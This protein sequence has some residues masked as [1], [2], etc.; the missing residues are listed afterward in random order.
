MAVTV[1][2]GRDRGQEVRD[3]GNSM[4]SIYKTYKGAKDRDERKKI[5]DD[6]LNDEAKKELDLDDGDV[7]ITERKGKTAGAG[8]LKFPLVDMTDYS[9]PS[10]YKPNM[11]LNN[12][13]SF[14]A[15]GTKV[16]PSARNIPTVLYRTP[17]INPYQPLQY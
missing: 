7:D 9:P 15:L 12:Q 17:G 6:L 3:I 13:L 11:P 8:R 10:G 16:A 4:S 5:A 2:E 1:I 14:G